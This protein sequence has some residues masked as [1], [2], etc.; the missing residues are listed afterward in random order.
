MGALTHSRLVSVIIPTYNEETTIVDALQAAFRLRGDLEV[1]VADGQSSDQTRA[2]AEA[3]VDYSP[4]S[5]RVVA[6]R[7]GRAYQLNHAA[8]VAAGQVLLFLHADTVLAPE[9]LEALAAAMGDLSIVGGSFRVTFDGESAWSRVFTWVDRVRRRFGIYYGDA[10]LFVRRDVFTRL[11]GFR[12]MPVMEDY[13]FVRRLER[14]GRTVCLAP[15]IRVSDR[16][17]QVRGVFRTLWSWFWVQL[18][19]SLGVPTRYLAAWYRPVRKPR[20]HGDRAS[21]PECLSGR[22]PSER[23]A[24]IAAGREGSLQDWQRQARARSDS[25]AELIFGRLIG[26][27]AGDSLL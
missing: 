14:S 2:A 22:A 6:T 20:K 25:Q 19:Y 4:C 26:K 16:R 23:H 24:A 7:C 11:G 13:E 9:A 10:G 17:W 18:L 15:C 5:L 8:Q 3:L 21:I 12:P 27:I 1:I